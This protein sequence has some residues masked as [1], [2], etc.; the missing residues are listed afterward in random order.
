MKKEEMLKTLHMMREAVLCLADLNIDNTQSL[1]EADKLITAI[2]AIPEAPDS[3]FR[4]D[5][6]KA[7]FSKEPHNNS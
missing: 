4:P 7:I 1:V 5:P 3:R 2:E 6:D